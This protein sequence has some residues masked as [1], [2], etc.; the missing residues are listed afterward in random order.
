MRKDVVVSEYVSLIVQ[1]YVRTGGRGQVCWTGLA[2]PNTC[3]AISSTLLN[4]W[5][6][7]HSFVN[8]H[9]HQDVDLQLALHIV[10]GHIRRL[11][12]KHTMKVWIR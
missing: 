9:D 8:L 1:C 12:A 4:L 7:G 10:V 3:W 2:A 5:P 11:E 6:F